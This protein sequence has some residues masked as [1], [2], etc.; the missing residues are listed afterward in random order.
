[1]YDGRTDGVG[2]VNSGFIFTRSNCRTKI[3]LQTMIDNIVFFLWDRASQPFVNALMHHRKFR[4]ISM[5]LL[6][7]ELFMNGNRWTPVKAPDDWEKQGK[8]NCF[9]SSSQ[10][11]LFCMCVRNK[12]QSLRHARLMDRK[13]LG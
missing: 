1:M 11:I 4:Q 10:I 13:S 5:R 9:F 6:D 12:G 7:V 3:Y 2:P 8:P